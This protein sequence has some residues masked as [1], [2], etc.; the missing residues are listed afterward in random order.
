MTYRFDDNIVSVTQHRDDRLPDGWEPDWDPDEEQYQPYGRGGRNLGMLTMLVLVDDQI[1]DTVRRPV[2][3]SGYEC[4]ARE[5]GRGKPKP[6]P[7]VVEVPAQPRHELELTWLRR[8]VGGADELR[9]LTRDPLPDEPLDLSS[10]PADLRGR[11]ASI[12]E[13]VDEVSMQLL[14]PE[15]RTACRRLLTRAVTAEPGML[16]G[17]DRDDIAAGAVVYATGKGN[18]LIGGLCALTATSLYQHCGLRSSP[19]DR[20][21]RFAHAVSGPAGTGLWSSYSRSPDVLLGSADLLTSSF[22]SSLLR[23]RDIAMAEATSSS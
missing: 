7:R 21:R 10:V 13:R 14:G 5:L 19:H 20:A 23:L 2:E 3:G 18:D 11:V 6:G 4:A 8:L 22:R 9:D 17:N 12:A 1:I 16:R 15:A